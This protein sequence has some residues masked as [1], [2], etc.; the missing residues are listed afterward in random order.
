MGTPGAAD[1]SSVAASKRRG[2][3]MLLS[4]LASRCHN[5]VTSTPT[6]AERAGDTVTQFMLLTRHPEALHYNGIRPLS[7]W[8]S[9]G[10]EGYAGSEPEVA[11]RNEVELSEAS[12]GSGGACWLEGLQRLRQYRPRS[13]TQC[14][15]DA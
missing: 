1:N 14:L 12:A 9:S 5:V 15:G 13:S 4:R 3:P 2:S 6:S 8:R 11:G 10:R 7:D